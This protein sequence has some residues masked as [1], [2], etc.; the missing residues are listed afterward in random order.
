MVQSKLLAF[1]PLGTPRDKVHQFLTNN[2]GKT[3]DIK[4][5]DPAGGIGKPDAVSS[6]FVTLWSRYWWCATF[7]TIA[8]Y[9]FDQKKRLNDLEAGTATT[10]F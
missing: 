6:I 5:N 9:G 1:T 2:I 7:D 8:V 4:V 3:A 10:A